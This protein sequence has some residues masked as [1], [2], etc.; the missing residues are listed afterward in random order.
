MEMRKKTRMLSH[1][2]HIY[3]HVYVIP[4]TWQDGKDEH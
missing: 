3:S 2:I 1:L 4:A